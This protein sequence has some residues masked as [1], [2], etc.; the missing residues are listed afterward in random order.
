M[1]YLAPRTEDQSRQLGCLAGAFR[2]AARYAYD[3]LLACESSSI[4]VFDEDDLGFLSAV[5]IDE[6]E[7]RAAE[8]APAQNDPNH[9]LRPER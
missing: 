6:I 9:W 8:R 7:R 2:I 3:D 4:T 1:K 5:L